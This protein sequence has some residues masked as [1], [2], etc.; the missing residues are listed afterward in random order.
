VGTRAARVIDGGVDYRHRC[1]Q[2]DGGLNVAKVRLTTF[3]T[4]VAPLFGHHVYL[5]WP[6]S[7]FLIATVTMP[8][9]VDTIVFPFVTIAVA[10]YDPIPLIKLEPL[11]YAQNTSRE[12]IGMVTGTAPGSTTGGLKIPLS[13]HSSSFV[14]SFPCIH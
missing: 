12:P 6:T 10:F 2:L 13:I 14:I 3:S 7:P 4:N 1:F 5:R 8:L 11:D 9:L